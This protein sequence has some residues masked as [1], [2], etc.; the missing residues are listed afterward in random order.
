MDGD[1]LPPCHGASEWMEP[2]QMEEVS[3]EETSLA[4]SWAPPEWMEPATC[5]HQPMLH[6]L[7]RQSTRQEQHRE[8]QGLPALD[9]GNFEWSLESTVDR[10]D[11]SRQRASSHPAQLHQYCRHPGRPLHH[12]RPAAPPSPRPTKVIHWKRGKG[13][14]KQASLVNEMKSKG[15]K[16]ARILTVLR[17]SPPR[18]AACHCFRCCQIRRR[19]FLW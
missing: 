9:G 11:V 12:C 3:L 8:H 18:V 16:K 14:N 17:W 13:N 5:W 2:T 4:Q 6:E 19:N 15:N 10:S 7:E 1:G